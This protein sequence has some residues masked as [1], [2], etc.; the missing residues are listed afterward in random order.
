MG[1]NC[2]VPQ[3]IRNPFKLHFRRIHNR[4]LHTHHQS[5]PTIYKVGLHHEVFIGLDVWMAVVIYGVQCWFQQSMG[6]LFVAIGSRGL[7]PRIVLDV[8]TTTATPAYC[9]DCI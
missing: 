6:D 3:R 1:A 7:R 5:L 8:W 2:L 9:V 4:L